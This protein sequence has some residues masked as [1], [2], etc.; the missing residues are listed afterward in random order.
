MATSR[1]SFIQ[2]VGLNGLAVAAAGC[3]T[4]SPARTAWRPQAPPLGAPGT[5]SSLLRLS[6]NENSAGP[7]P[8]VLAAVQ[9]GFGSPTATPSA[10]RRAHGGRGR[11]AWRP[12]VA[13]DARLRVE[14]DPRR[15][16]GGVSRIGSRARHGDA[17]L[18]AA[19]G[20]RRRLGRAV[21]D[22]P[23]DAELRL[24]LDQMA[25]RASG[26]GL[27]Y[28]CNP[29][30]PTGTVHGAADIE[31]FVEAALQTEPNATILIDEAYHEYVEHAGL[32]DGHPARP[33]QP[34]R[35]RLAHVL[36]D[37]RH[38]GFARRLRGGAVGHAGVNEPVSRRR[39][40][41]LPE[42]P[43]GADGAGRP[44]ARGPRSGRTTRRAR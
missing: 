15:R 11:V 2:L 4:T 36:E 28:I 29:N 35:H 8:K 43:R 30:N 24:D 44:G 34:A 42:R 19:V 13:G 5:R 33:R 38:G 25:A 6:S 27:V 39:P 17:D 16:R 18:R 40:I 1:R 14:R 20:T 31:A 41:E 26:A 10:S 23:V 7:G 32:Q 37:L 9:D 21:V 22:V 3:A 12:A